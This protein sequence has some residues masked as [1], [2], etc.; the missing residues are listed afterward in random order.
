[1]TV[2]GRPICVGAL[3][4]N[5]VVERG[6]DP[7]VLLHGFPN[8]AALWRLLTPRLVGE[9]Y[10]VVAPDLRGAGGSD[11]PQ[12]KHQYALP[13]LADDVLGIMDSLGIERA[14][15][16]GHDWGALLGWLL[17][18]TR[19]ER[20]KT[21]TAVSVGHPRAYA[22][23][24]FAQLLRAWYIGLIALPGVA[25][26]VLSA[27]DWYLFRKAARH[28]DA[29]DWIADVSRPGRLTARLNWYR[30]NAFK[31]GT[32]TR[33]SLPVLGIWSSDDPALTEAQMTGSAKFVE[34][35]WRYERLDGVGHFIPL[36][37]PER[38]SALLLD[39]FRTA[40]A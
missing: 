30:E 7:V 34:G 22:R 26:R 2:E 18:G 28:R 20:F 14:H 27:R 33:T 16:V 21:F 12:G 8:S 4:F 11:A 23:A 24:G 3:T 9:G 32:K 15:L 37:E 36:D 1:M 17:A 38:L 13:L 29:D 25:E 6:L 19:A 5:V 10:A 31:P 40:G 35:P 39:F